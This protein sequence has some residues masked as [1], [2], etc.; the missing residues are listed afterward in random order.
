MLVNSTE[1]LIMSNISDLFPPSLRRTPAS[2]TLVIIIP[3]ERQ[4]NVKTCLVPDWKQ[5]KGVHPRIF[6]DGY[7]HMVGCSWLV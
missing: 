4:H 1:I 7:H 2:E 6:S 3:V 5:D